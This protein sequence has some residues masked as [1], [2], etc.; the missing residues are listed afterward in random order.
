M[1]RLFILVLSSFLFVS[2]YKEYQ[3]RDIQQV[4][5]LNIS[6]DST[7]IR[8]IDAV[9]EKMAIFAGSNGII[10]NVYMRNDDWS[11][12]LSEKI[13]YKDTLIPNFRSVASNG[14]DIFAL[15]I[16]NPALLTKFN[17]SETDPSTQ[18]DVMGSYRLVYKEVHE[19]VFYDSMKFFDTQNGIAMGDPTENCLSIIITQDG[20]DTWAKIPCD[21]L[22]K[23]EKGEAAFAASNT[24]IKVIGKTAWIVTGGAKAR[25]FKTTDL[26][27]SWSVFDTPIICGNG[28][29]GIY[30]VDFADENNGILIGGDYSNPRENKANKAITKDGGKTW[31]LVADKSEPAYKSCIQFVP[32]TQG[33]EV[34][35]VGFTGISYSKDGGL[36]WKEIS[37]EAYYTIDFVDRNHAWLAGKEKI[38]YLKLN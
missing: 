28:P 6:V 20:G 18:S 13:R 19:K 30:S 27:K 8:A 11:V 15:S 32:N 21:K 3:A 33:K 4:S 17:A 35:A 14:K 16:G 12:S 22:P 37:K 34:F 2:C 24:N 23:V 36:T 31:Q 10:G 29:Q 9:D 26:G 7:S 38:G 5:I 25:V 1:Q